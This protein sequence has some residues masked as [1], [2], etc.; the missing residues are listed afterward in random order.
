MFR[1][2]QGQGDLDDIPDGEHEQIEYI[3]E[4]KEKNQTQNIFHQASFCFGSLT[5]ICRKSSWPFV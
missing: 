4:M 5:D 3:N 1:R 2:H